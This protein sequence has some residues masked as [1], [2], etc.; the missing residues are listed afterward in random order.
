[1]AILTNVRQ[2]VDY[3]FSATSGSIFSLPIPE[4]VSGSSN[5]VAMCIT[6]I[7]VPRQET[8]IAE[9]L[10]MEVDFNLGFQ[11]PLKLLMDRCEGERPPECFVQTEQAI[12]ETARAIAKRW[13]Q[14]EESTKLMQET[15]ELPL[16]LQS[17]AAA[18]SCYLGRGSV[19]MSRAVIVAP[20]EK[21]QLITSAGSTIQVFLRGILSITVE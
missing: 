21:L 17:F 7:I 11:L 1:M 5:D 13:K 20:R 14:G 18:L 6:D 2:R 15:R 12:T 19:Q 10:R 9:T 8:K 16:L 3:A 4:L